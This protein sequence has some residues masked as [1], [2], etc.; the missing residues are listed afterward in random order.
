VVYRSTTTTIETDKLP[1]LQMVADRKLSDDWCWSL[2]EPDVLLSFTLD[3]A[4]GGDF[5]ARGDFFIVYSL[6]R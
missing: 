4:E 2:L 1:I 5:G 3:L 6:A